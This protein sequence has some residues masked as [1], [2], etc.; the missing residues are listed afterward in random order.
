LTTQNYLAV[1]EKV[2]KPSK[3]PIDGEQK[4]PGRYRVDVT[5]R[6]HQLLVARGPLK[7]LRRSDSAP[8]RMVTILLW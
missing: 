5:A 8:N 6:S 4:S 1:E 3:L 7:D 2:D